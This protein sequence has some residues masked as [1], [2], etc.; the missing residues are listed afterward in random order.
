MSGTTAFNHRSVL[1]ASLTMF[2]SLG[3]LLMLAWVFHGRDISH[4]NA[5]SVQDIGTWAVVSSP[6]PITY[7]LNSVA[8]VS[9]SDGWAVGSKGHG[10]NGVSYGP[11]ILHWDGN[12]WS[13]VPIS[14]TMPFDDLESVIM[15]SAN[16][17]WAVGGG[18]WWGDSFGSTLH[19]DGN[20]WDKMGED[21]SY[22]KSVAAVSAGDVW[23]VGVYQHTQL[24]IPRTTIF[25]SATT[26][27]NG[28]T[29]EGLIT[30]GRSGLNSVAMVS[31]DDGWAVGY[32][33]WVY[34]PG[35]FQ[36]L[37]L[38]W[39]G[40]GWT[41]VSVPGTA[42]LM[43][44]AM[45]SPNDGWAVGKEGAI[46]RWDGS[47]WSPVSSPVTVTLY[48]VA[49]VSSADGWAVGD[50]GTILHWDGSVWSQVTS[51]VTQTLKSVTMISANEG[52]A[53]G[54][55]GTILHY[56]NFKRMYLPLVVR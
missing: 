34:P 17:A 15:V 42:S 6:V 27:W 22:L 9:N 19:W 13:Q 37:I 2:L 20:T 3:S 38:H 14:G 33:T 53:V 35:E 47:T 16:D 31:T 51:P 28:N 4:A 21:L 56:T 46:L 54:K 39:D 1:S 49:M 23:A 18:D 11:F 43:S 10:P 44:V 7:S 50:I 41:K 36:S 40:K 12:K 29:W 24:T 8:A 30:I 26:H 48:S 25:G 55:E 45:V 5:A 32:R 52:W